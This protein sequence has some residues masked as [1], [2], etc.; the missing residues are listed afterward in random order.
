MI[1]QPELGKKIAEHRKAKGLTQEELVEKCNLSVRTLQR[2]EAGEVIPRTST[3]KLIFEAL[4]LEFNNPLFSAIK[5]NKG[6]IIKWSEQFYKYF[7]DLFNLKTQTM[8]KITIL[9]VL[10][11]GIIIVISNI[12]DNTY[13]QK[14]TGNKEEKPQYENTGKG[15]DG[16][17]RYSYFQSEESFYNNDNLIGRNTVFTSNGVTIS[18]SL[19]LINESTHEFKTSYASG[20]LTKNQVEIF[21]SRE[22][23][24]SIKYSS[25][26]E[27]VSYRNFHLIGDAKIFLG[28]NRYI[29][30]P[31]IILIPK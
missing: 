27:R 12:T 1:Q 30:A 5:D 15:E 6:L 2:I 20:K 7:I 3:V 21:C 16:S 31:E 14:E 17:M 4:E 9:T 10:L 26:E 22:F 11:T 24:D 28:E 19:I 29:E 23:R 25:M 18:S 13:A 8:K